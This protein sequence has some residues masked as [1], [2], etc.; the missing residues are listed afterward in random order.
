MELLG[1]ILLVLALLAGLIAVVFGLPGT[2]LILA[3]SIIYAWATDF[4]AITMQLVLGLLVLA[5]LAELVDYTA[6][7]WGTRRYGGSKMAMVGTLIG[8]LLGA[9]AFA[10]ILLG[11]GSVVGAF[12]GAFC[13]AFGVTYL[14]QRKMGEAVRVGWGAFLGKVFAT[15][16]K[17]AVAVAMIGIDLWAL[18]SSSGA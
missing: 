13:G 14:E 7:V 10:P 12:L 4:A 6:G 1:L 18:F 9:I 16:F 2:W 3:A 17:G 11:L 15:V 5:A 8:G